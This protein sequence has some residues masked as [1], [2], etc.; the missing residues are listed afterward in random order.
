MD[1]LLDTHL[2]Y[3]YLL[4]SDKIPSLAKDIIAD[5]S[6][7]VFVSLVSAWEIGLKHTK[8]PDQMPMDAETFIHG[9]EEAGFVVLPLVENQLLEAMKI[10]SPD[11]LDHQD[12]FDRFLLGA[13]SALRMRFLTHDA[14][15]AAYKSPFVLFL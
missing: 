1:L 7:A 6:N 13:A 9:C 3:W 15:I 14:K 4:G 10:P 5:G 12:P 11:G 2:A 8:R